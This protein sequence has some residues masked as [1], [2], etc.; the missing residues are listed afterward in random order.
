VVLIVVK[1]RRDNVLLRDAELV[2]RLQPQQLV[3]VILPHLVAE[4]PECLARP[5]RL[6]SRHSLRVTI[7]A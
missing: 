3:L 6:A 4:A 1:T 2:G 5:D 7:R